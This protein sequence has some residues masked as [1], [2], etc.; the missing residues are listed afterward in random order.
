MIAA[1]VGGI[2]VSVEAVDAREARLRALTE[3]VIGVEAAT[4]GV[5]ESQAPTEAELLPDVTAR[6][7]LGSVYPGDPRQ[8]DNTHRH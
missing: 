3:R 2:A 7:E 1:T 6:L 4:L 8:P 5:A